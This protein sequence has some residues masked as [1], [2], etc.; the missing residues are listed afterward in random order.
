[1]GVIRLILVLLLMLPVVMLCFYLFMQCANY[2]LGSKSSSSEARKRSTGDRGNRRLQTS[3]RPTA[4]RVSDGYYN[5]ET[6]PYTEYMR[7]QGERR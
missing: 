5:R 2:A 7:R 1:M 4:Q 3:S 6:D